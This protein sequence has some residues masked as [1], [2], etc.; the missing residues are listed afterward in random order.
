M[1]A[2]TLELQTAFIDPDTKSIGKKKIIN[3]VSQIYLTN[4]FLGNDFLT[5]G[6]E[7]ISN[8][9]L[10]PEKRTDALAHVSLT[11]LTQLIQSLRQWPP[12]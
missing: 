9:N 12:E 2:L 3:F 8:S 7:V 6:S 11:T 10:D 5:Y 1:K 4:K